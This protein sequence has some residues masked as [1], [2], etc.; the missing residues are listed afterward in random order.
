MLLR[1]SILIDVEN[2]SI[3]YFGTFSGFSWH[4]LVH[5]GI[6]RYK[7]SNFGIPLENK[8]WAGP[9]LLKKQRHQVKP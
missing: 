5:F 7:N 9:N 4:V 8:D 6:C 2:N 1:A 3:S